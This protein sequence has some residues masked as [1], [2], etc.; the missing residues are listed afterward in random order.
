MGFFHHALSA[1]RGRCSAAAKP[2]VA[3]DVSAQHCSGMREVHIQ[4]HSQVLV[5]TQLLP[6]TPTQFSSSPVIQSA[7]YHFCGGSAPTCRWAM[8]WS[9]CTA[10]VQRWH[11]PTVLAQS[12]RCVQCWASCGGC[13]LPG[14][15]MV[16]PE[17]VRP[18]LRGC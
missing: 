7:G 3:W 1:L 9:P 14:F 13:F 5:G 10:G 6:R 2:P 11:K 18:R 12:A 16:P 4:T 15:E 8:V 17:M